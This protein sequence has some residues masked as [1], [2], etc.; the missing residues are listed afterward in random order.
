VGAEHQHEHDRR[1]EQSLPHVPSSLN[2]V[3]RQPY[4]CHPA[5]IKR[6]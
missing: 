5:P 4:A 3:L 2:A 1:Y 6:D